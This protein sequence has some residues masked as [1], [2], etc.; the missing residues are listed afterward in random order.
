MPLPKFLR[1]KK[2]T[3]GTPLVNPVS[4][5]FSLS[6][7]SIHGSDADLGPPLVDHHHTAE[8]CSIQSAYPPL[9]AMRRIT[10][11]MLV[12]RID[13]SCSFSPRPLWPSASACSKGQ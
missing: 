3:K 6:G 12:L 2:E 1:R 5:A 9:Y 11:T 7:W 8:S 10:L 13:A 4:Y